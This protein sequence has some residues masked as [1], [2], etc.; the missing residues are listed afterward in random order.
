L[1][2]SSLWGLVLFV[3]LLAPGLAYVIH[4]E[5]VVP[6]RSHTAFREGLRVVFT[7][8]VCL[9]ITVVLA[10]ILHGLLPTRTPDISG[11]IADPVS[12]LA[13]NR[14]WY[15]WWAVGALGFA[16]V[17]GW[18]LAHPRFIDG[19]DRL[20]GTKVGRWFTGATDLDIASVSAW[21]TVFDS[22]LREVGG[23]DVDIGA[24]L[25]DNTYIEGRL[26]SFNPDPTENTDREMVL[27]Q[28]LY[29]TVDGERKALD[30]QYVIIS[31]RRILRLDADLIA[32][33]EPPKPSTIQRFWRW[34][35]TKAG[36]IR[37]RLSERRPTT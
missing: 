12:E 30:R 11:L 7:S 4:H 28:P 32:P 21:Y 16:T 20:K 27:E 5:Q 1:I 19:S 9:T 36:V 35:R 31:A 14:V 15:V 24:K 33:S 13:G 8:I 34:L 23:Q 26:R 22:F 10:A 2:P 18:A 17:L 25:D 37:K 3:V 29:C 6:A